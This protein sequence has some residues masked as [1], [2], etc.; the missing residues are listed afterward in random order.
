MLKNHLKYSPSSY[1]RWLTAR[2]SYRAWL[3]IPKPQQL[4]GRFLWIRGQSGLH[5]KF[6]AN[7][8]YM[9]RL[10]F[11]K[12]KWIKNKSKKIRKKP[13][14]V[15]N[16]SDPFVLSHHHLWP[17]FSHIS[18]YVHTHTHSSTIWLISSV[19]HLGHCSQMGKCLFYY[20]LKDFSL[21]KCLLATKGT[22]ECQFKTL[23][24]C[25]SLNFSQP[26]LFNWSYALRNI[27]KKKSAVKH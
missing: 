27:S 19:S 9:G 6:E 22:L 2:K 26:I 16:N 24:K 15:C 13:S 23:F 20:N 14:A 21:V 17:G 12:T 25:L 3:H 1:A 4:A 7:Q 11:K 10:S 8:W 18:T 5:R